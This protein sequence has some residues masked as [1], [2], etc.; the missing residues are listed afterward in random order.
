LGAAGTSSRNRPARARPAAAEGAEEFFLIA[1]AVAQYA[2][3]A[4]FALPEG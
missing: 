1:A 3:I 4:F 2:A